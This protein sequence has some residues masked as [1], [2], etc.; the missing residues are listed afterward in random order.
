VMS[1]PASVGLAVAVLLGGAMLALIAP[2]R[3][4]TMIDPNAALRE[5]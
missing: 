4:A 3:R 5:E 2:V 1:D